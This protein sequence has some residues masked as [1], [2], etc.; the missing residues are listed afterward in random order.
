MPIVNISTGIN[1]AVSLSENVSGSAEV[2]QRLCDRAGEGVMVAVENCPD[3]GNIAVNPPL[4]EAL[5]E[6]VDR[7]NFRLTYDPSHL[8][9]LGIEPYE[10]LYEF[11]PHIIHVPRQRHRG[12]LGET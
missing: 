5:I 10:P 3:T 6:A 1:P 7:P 8:V 9:R 4:W 11:G 2:L 12:H